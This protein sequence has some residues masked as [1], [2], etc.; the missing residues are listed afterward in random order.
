[1]D[2]LLLSCQ[3][4]HA[5]LCSYIWYVL[6]HSIHAITS[7]RTNGNSTVQQELKINWD[8]TVA[9]ELICMRN[10]QLAFNPRS[11]RI[12]AYSWSSTE[13]QHLNANSFAC[14]I[15]NSHSTRV[16]FAYLH[17]VEAQLSLNSWTWAHLHVNFFFKLL[18]SWSS[19]ELQLNLGWTSLVESL[20][21]FGLLEWTGSPMFCTSYNICVANK[22]PCNLLM[23]VW[24]CNVTTIHDMIL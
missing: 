20:S 17:I 19:T 18:H 10:F 2:S 7:M 14:E 13:L 9:C 5:C 3:G 22:T 21:F 1:M 4:L 6:H 24:L 15:F 12:F 23:F 11:T 16:Q 8:S